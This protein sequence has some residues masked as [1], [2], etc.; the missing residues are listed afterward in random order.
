ML[1]AL[2]LFCSQGGASMGLH[3]AGYDVTGVDILPQPRYPFTFIQGDALEFDLSG[4]NL[5]WASPP[6][7]AFSELTPL[8]SRANHPDLID[9]IRTRLQ[10]QAAPWIIENVAGARRKLIN[11]FMLC[12]SMF[13][14]DVWRHR[15]FELGNTNAF[16]LVPPCDHSFQPVVVSGRGMRK[17][18]EGHRWSGSKAQE[19]ADAMQIDWM[20][21]PGLRQAIPPAYAKFLAEQ[22]QKG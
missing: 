7:Q 18:A 17:T 13:G 5:I 8:Q 1:K 9:P 20:N 14:L 2:D 19:S 6:C 4:Y 3:Q 21:R 10:Q 15:Y 11:P 16:F 12:G 22:I